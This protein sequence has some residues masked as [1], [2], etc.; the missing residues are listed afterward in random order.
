M[1]GE[2]GGGDAAEGGGGVREESNWSVL[3]RDYTERK[4]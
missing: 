1:E 2:V 3:V 4:I